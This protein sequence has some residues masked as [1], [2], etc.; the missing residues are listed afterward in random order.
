MDDTSLQRLW[1]PQ[2]AFEHP[3]S[4]WVTIVAAAALVL[5]PALTVVLG[6]AGIM[7]RRTADD[8]R[9]RLRT[10]WIITPLLLGP[11]LL[12]AGPAIV[13]FTVATLL[14]YREFARATGLFR[15]RG[16]SVLVGV[17][18][19]LL[20]LASLDNYYRMFVAVPS[21]GM[22]VIAAAAVVMDQPK[23]YIQRVAL[24]VLG[25]VLVGS[26]LMH[27]A[28]LCND[29]AYRPMLCMII[30]GVQLNDMMAYC[31]GKALGRRKVFPNTSPNKTL[32]GHV[33]AIVIA[34][35]LVAI[36][37]R[38]V[39]G[40]TTLGSWPWCTAIGLL[41]SVG[42]QLGDLVLGSIKRD[43]GM[44]DLANTLPGHGGFL[45]RFN[46]SLLVAPAMFHLI[47]ATIGVGSGQPVKIL[48]SW[49][50]RLVQGG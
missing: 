13:M 23:G 45:D 1:S 24:G 35:P 12:G 38:F 5:T 30:A 50:L 40:G 27:L 37:A 7:S 29:A 4:M 18:I 26:C 34:A 47:N 25:L 41:I 3:V 20:G 28:F 44:K 22:G 16:V 49:L 31:C 48:S 8:V 36:M 2:L 42:G 33:G 46:S 10:W 6:R 9:V 32:A 14:C 21:T 43:L 19:V 11:I 15:E 39:F 17:G